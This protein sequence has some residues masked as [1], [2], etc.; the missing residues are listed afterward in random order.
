MATET[1]TKE[2]VTK[3]LKDVGVDVTKWDWTKFAAFLKLLLS[4]FL[5]QKQQLKGMGCSEHDCAMHEAINH[6]LEAAYLCSNCC[7]PDEPAA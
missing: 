4:I 6:N 3:A 5:Q 1:V 2:Q 7:C